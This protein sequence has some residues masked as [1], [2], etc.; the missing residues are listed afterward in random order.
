MQEHRAKS[1]SEFVDLIERLQKKAMAPLWYRGCSRASHSLLPSLYRKRPGPNHPTTLSELESELVARF[2]ERSLP[3]Q[4]RPLGNDALETLFLMQHFGVPTRLLDWTENPFSGLYFALRDAPHHFT[5]TGR[6]SFK[7]KAVVWVLDPA[8]W[9]RG[10]LTQRSFAGGVLSPAHETLTAYRPIGQIEDLA[11]RP[12]ALYGAHNS[13]RIVAQQGVF[14]LFG[15]STDPMEAVVQRPEFTQQCL[16]RI[17]IM[18]GVIRNL[19]EALWRNGVTD[20]AMFPDLEGL[21]RDLRRSFGF[22]I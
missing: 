3:Y 21:A 16:T 11:P 7:Q 8:S 15:S 13:P 2:R 10:A 19:R 17:V 6:L 22:A 20:A 18:P 1:L 5:K 9:N 14:V 12:V 4:I